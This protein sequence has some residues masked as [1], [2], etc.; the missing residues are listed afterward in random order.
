MIVITIIAIIIIIIIITHIITPIIIF[1]SS[2]FY[3]GIRLQLHQLH[4]NMKNNKD[5]YIYIYIKKQ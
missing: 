2:T 3:M 1:T 5:I 4:L